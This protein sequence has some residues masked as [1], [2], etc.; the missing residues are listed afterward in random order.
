[1]ASGIR[2]ITNGQFRLVGRTFFNGTFDIFPPDR[3]EHLLN[4]CEWKLRSTEQSCKA[5]V[6]AAET[7]KREALNSV[8]AIETESNKQKQEVGFGIV[9]FFVCVVVF[10]LLVAS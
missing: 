5:K 1:M 4:D 2:T 9:F 6:L 8:T 3:E 10:H 7:A